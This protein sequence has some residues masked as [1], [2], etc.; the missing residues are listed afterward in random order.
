MNYETISYG[1]F[2]LM[3]LIHG[4]LLIRSHVHDFAQIIP[5]K[6]LFPFYCVSVALNLMIFGAWLEWTWTFLLSGIVMVPLTIYN[7]Q[8]LGE[9]IAVQRMKACDEEFRYQHAKDPFAKPEP[10]REFR[11]FDPDPKLLK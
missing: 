10:Q 3:T 5:F 9:H 8:K 2:G 11:I 7:F 4:W 6:F 1:L